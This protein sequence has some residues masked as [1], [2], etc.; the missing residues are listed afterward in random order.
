MLGV[1]FKETLRSAATVSRFRG[2]TFLNLKLTSYVHKTNIMILF[3]EKIIQQTKTE[4]IWSLRDRWA[5]TRC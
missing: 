5:Y 2:M 1:Q 3:N 4:S